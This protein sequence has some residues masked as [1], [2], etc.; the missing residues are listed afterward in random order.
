M[1]RS[2][3]AEERQRLLTQAN[4]RIL[5]DKPELIPD[6]LDLRNQVWK[7]LPGNPYDDKYAKPWLLS[8]LEGEVGALGLD[9]AALIGNGLALS[10]SLL[11]KPNMWLMAAGG[12]IGVAAGGVKLVRDG[13]GLSRKELGTRLRDQDHGMLTSMVSNTW[14]FEEALRK[15]STNPKANADMRNAAALGLD[16]MTAW[17]RQNGLPDVDTPL[18]QVVAQ[19]SDLNGEVAKARATAAQEHNPS[20]DYS[21]FE[22]AFLAELEKIGQGVSDVKEKM[23]PLWDDLQHRMEQEALAAE[24]A[25]LEHTL[26]EV[27]AAG[28]ILGFVVGL[29]DPRR[30]AAITTIFEQGAVAFKAY[31]AMQGAAAAGAAIEIASIASGIG[32]VFAI[33]GALSAFGGGS[34]GGP[35]PIQLMMEAL[36]A[37]MDGIN[38][39]GAQIQALSEAVRDLGKRTNLNFAELDRG[40]WQITTQISRLDDTLRRMKLEDIERELFDSLR[41]FRSDGTGQAAVALLKRAYSIALSDATRNSLTGESM[42]PSQLARRVRGLADELALQTGIGSEGSGLTGSVQLLSLALEIY[43]TLLAR[44][45]DAFMSAGGEARRAFYGDHLFVSSGLA[46]PLSGMSLADR[47][48][49]HP[50]TATRAVAAAVE[51]SRH[52]LLR[53]DSRPKTDVGE[54]LELPEMLRDIV[55]AAEWPRRVV[56]VVG[57]PVAAK[58]AAIAYAEAIEALLEW[59]LLARTRHTGLLKDWPLAYRSGVL[60]GAC[61]VAEFDHGELRSSW[62]MSFDDIHASAGTPQKNGGQGYGS[63]LYRDEDL[64]QAFEALAMAARA[65]GTVRLESLRA[66]VGSPMRNQPEW[67][68]SGDYHEQVKITVQR[69]D[70]AKPITWFYVELRDPGWYD[71][72]R[73]QHGYMS[74]ADKRSLF[75]EQPSIMWRY[76]AGRGREATQWEDDGAGIA[77]NGAPFS[78]EAYSAIE[79]SIIAVQNGVEGQGFQE[80]A[81]SLRDQNI[82]FS[83]YLGEIENPGEVA[84]ASVFKSLCNELQATLPGNF[85]LPASL[86]ENLSQAWL[87]LVST[88]LAALDFTPAQAEA[89]HTRVMLTP[90]LAYAADELITSTFNSLHIQE[91]QWGK[92]LQRLIKLFD[93]GANP[94]EL[95]VAVVPALDYSSLNSLERW[96]DMFDDDVILAL[97]VEEKKIKVRVR[98]PAMLHI[99]QSST[100]KTNPSLSLTSCLP[101]THQAMA[102][103]RDFSLMQMQLAGWNLPI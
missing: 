79:A 64:S 93:E 66:W 73:L 8:N 96:N 16:R 83:L 85:S 27:V 75:D 55:R 7:E 37:I 62:S 100:G 24:Q 72:S 18:D 57:S 25:A 48:A 9:G 82:E 23:Q 77:P 34:G 43:P 35:D 41:D 74:I 90:P 91:A 14:A 17:R 101:N 69:P 76:S 3:T 102:I 4:L 50:V 30:G 94:Q 65:G 68:G 67:F 71:N 95:T 88:G 47:R 28:Q 60:L 39:L 58:E 46:D 86:Q 78:D 63:E 103:A 36:N 10:A 42:V 87:N 92:S 21:K 11:T 84:Q 32:A 56:E 2:L 49:I 19:V 89:L 31:R 51:A 6:F 20:K 80:L 33:A 38:Q 99:A 54:A 22:S 12:V 1:S 44:A 70:E 26:G 13:Q 5:H 29:G 61:K 53:P 45:A 97:Y 98:P 40:L 81:I 52:L 15:I 59:T